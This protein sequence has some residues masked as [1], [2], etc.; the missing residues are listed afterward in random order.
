M[1]SMSKP[2]VAPIYS[3]GEEIAHAITHGVGV[4]ASIV[5]LAVLVGFAAKWGNAWHLVG[6]SIFGATLILTY[7]AS[8]LYHS[9]P[10]ERAKRILRSLDHS[11]IFLLIAGTYTPFTLVN[12][13]G[14]WGWSILGV[15]WGIAIFGI[16]LE[17]TPLRSIRAIPIVLYLVLGWLIVI[18]TKPMFATVATG[19]LVLVA[20]GGLVYTVG[21]I[22]YGLKR[23]RYHHAIWHVFVM[24]G[25]TLHFFAVLLYVIP[26]RG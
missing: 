17:F 6:C 7:T 19:G 26:V 20:T 16:V 4:V 2:R 24:V 21:I 5:G 9:I 1:G 12:L 10:L 11:A 22:F 13:R 8:T 15:V 25:S 3:L 18:A 23:M 14:P